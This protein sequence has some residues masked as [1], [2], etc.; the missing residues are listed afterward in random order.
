MKII[1]KI[2]CLICLWVGLLRPYAVFAQDISQETAAVEAAVNQSAETDWEHRAKLYRGWGWGLF[3]V[4]L[5]FTGLGIWLVVDHPKRVRR[6]GNCDPSGE[7][8]GT[9][10]GVGAVLILAGG[11]PLVVGI[12]LLIAD[13][14][15][16]NP[17]RRGEV[18]NGFEW[19]PDIFVSPQMSGIGISGRF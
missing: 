15:K 3:G 13:A 17:Y 18:A 4:G 10:A 12:G 11:I 7:G 19:H 5:V 16:F 6:A 9:G 2:L 14:V 8:C 1:I